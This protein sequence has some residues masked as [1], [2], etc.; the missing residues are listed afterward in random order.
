MNNLVSVK[1]NFTSGQ[2]SKNLFGRGDLKIFENGARY[3][4]NIIIHPTGGISRRKG[5]KVIE[6]ISKYAILI[7]FEFIT[8]QI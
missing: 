5:T 8:E 6:E 3:L 1:T 4:E 2:I 7:P